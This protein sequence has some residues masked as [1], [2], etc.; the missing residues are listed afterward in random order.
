MD[1]VCIFLNKGQKNQ[2]NESLIALLNPLINLMLINEEVTMQL[3][4][5][6]CLK[7]FILTRNEQIIKLY[8]KKKKIA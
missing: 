5:S 6:I 3:H 1:I 8:I 2:A 7:T 4:A